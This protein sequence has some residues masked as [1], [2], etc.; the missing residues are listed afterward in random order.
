MTTF[1]SLS[2]PG[3]WGPVELRF[4]IESLLRLTTCPVRQVAS[5]VVVGSSIIKKA[6]ANTVLVVVWRTCGV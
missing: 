2:S 6:V 4:V 3:P 1:L 5:R